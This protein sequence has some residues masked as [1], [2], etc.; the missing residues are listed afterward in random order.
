MISVGG[1]SHNVPM[2]HGPL[3]F[4]LGHWDINWVLKFA[5]YLYQIFM[6]INVPMIW[7]IGTFWDINWVAPAPAGSAWERQ[8]SFRSRRDWMV[9][10]A[11]DQLLAED[12]KC[13][14]QNRRRRSASRL[15][16]WTCIRSRVDWQ[17]A[18]VA[19]AWMSC[20]AS[21]EPALFTFISESTAR[22]SVAARSASWM[23]PWTTSGDVLFRVWRRPFWINFQDSL[24][25]ARGFPLFRR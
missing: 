10:S 18:A 4:E 11:Y 8:S 15:A 23:W 14:N 16:Y 9:C 21:R 3:K 7:D 5:M 25:L 19:L 13:A 22:I 12:K 2:S 6:R 1:G 24:P 20:F 17:I